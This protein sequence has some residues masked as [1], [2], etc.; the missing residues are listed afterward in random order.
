MEGPDGARPGA[1]VQ[2]VPREVGAGRARRGRVLLEQGVL[3]EADRVRGAPDGEGQEGIHSHAEGR[4]FNGRREEEAKEEERVVHI[5]Q[6]DGQV[7]IREQVQIRPRAR[8]RRRERGAG[9]G[10]RL[11]WVLRPH[12]LRRQP[13]VG[14]DERRPREVLDGTGGRGRGGQGGDV[15][16]RQEPGVRDRQ[17]Q[18]G[19]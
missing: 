3:A 17:V 1:A 12:D 9:A 2:R 18:E 14:D 16:G 7:Q 10:P 8:Q 15:P 6:Q 4:R 11:F 5:V 19:N 13:A